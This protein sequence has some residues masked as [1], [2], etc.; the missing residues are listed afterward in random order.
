[1]LKIIGFLRKSR[2]YPRI[3]RQGETVM[4]ERLNQ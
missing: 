1:M 3:K 4:R 2:G